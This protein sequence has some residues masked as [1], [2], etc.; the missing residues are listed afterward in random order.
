MDSSI[1]NFTDGILFESMYTSTPANLFT[2]YE[3]PTFT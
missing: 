3:L 1:P 2:Y